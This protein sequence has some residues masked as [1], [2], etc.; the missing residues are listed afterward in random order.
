MKLLTLV[1]LVTLTLLSCSSEK[2]RLSPLQ[3]SINA[4]SS[5]SAEEVRFPETFTEKTGKVF[6]ASELSSHMSTIP[7][8]R[9]SAL[10]VEVNNL[11]FQ[12]KE[13]VYA[14]GS[15]NLVGQERA[16]A[17]VEKSY[18]KIQSLRK[19]LTPQDDEVINRYLVRIKSNIAQLEAL[20]KAERDKKP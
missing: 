9:N 10:N 1:L 5:S 14:V 16:L 2:V 18:K 20:S 12:V 7:K 4:S 11:K 19:Y 6:Y 17:Q 13:Y 15:Y 3:S 8:F